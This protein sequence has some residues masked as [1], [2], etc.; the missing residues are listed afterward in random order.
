MWLGRRVGRD[1]WAQLPDPDHSP[2]A[3][4]H[5]FVLQL[6]PCAPDPWRHLEAPHTF[7]PGPSPWSSRAQLLLHP[8]P[9][10]PL[11]ASPY[12]FRTHAFFKNNT[13]GHLHF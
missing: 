13:S 9:L 7:P 5:S 6:V 12:L 2:R 4:Q 3:R 1:G 8:G 11:V 10:C